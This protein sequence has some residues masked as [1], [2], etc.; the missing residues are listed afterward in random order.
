[1]AGSFA[2]RIRVLVVP[3]MIVVRSRGA[4]PEAEQQLTHMEEGR[5]LVNQVAAFTGVEVTDVLTDF[6]VS[7]DEQVIV[8]LFASHHE[9]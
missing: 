5:M 8:F 9:R 2:E 6:S 1:M 3:N 4:L 7:T